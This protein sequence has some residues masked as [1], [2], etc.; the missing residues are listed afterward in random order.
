MTDD[1]RKLL[2]IFGVTVTEF[3]ARAEKLTA[4]PRPEAATAEDVT[5]RMKEMADACREL[6]AR[7]LE[8]TRH[9]FAAQDRFLTAMVEG[10]D[11]APPSEGI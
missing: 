2:R 6:N 4:A 11:K 7:W 8:I 5:A 1:T 10:T 3:E 9:I